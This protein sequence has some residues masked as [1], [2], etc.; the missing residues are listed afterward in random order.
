MDPYMAKTE[1]LL[2]Q[3]R[4]RLD[5]LAA[6]MRAETPAFSANSRR[7]KLRKYEDRYADVSRRYDLL[8][9]AGTEGIADLK[10]GLEKAWA[11]FQEEIGWKP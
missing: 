4:A 7:R 3:G 9:S 10:V 11:A 6:P 5:W 8:R 2:R 1:A